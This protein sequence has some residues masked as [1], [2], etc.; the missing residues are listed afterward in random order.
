[1]AHCHHIN[2]Y[3]LAKAKVVNSQRKFEEADQFMAAS[4]H[5]Y[6]AARGKARQ[7][8]FTNG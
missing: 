5:Y 2:S 4:T 7:P 1:M 3:Y 6:D 8:E